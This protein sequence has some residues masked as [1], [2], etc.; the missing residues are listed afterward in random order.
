VD[1]KLTLLCTSL[2]N[3]TGSK[4]NARTI[5]QI[6]AF[7]FIMI[8]FIGQRTTKLLRE[9]RFFVSELQADLYVL[10]GMHYT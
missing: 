7:S 2:S 4:Q 6:N 9:T 8:L 5:Q 1:Q 10:N 3:T